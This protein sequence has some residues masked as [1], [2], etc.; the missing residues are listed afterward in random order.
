[1]KTQEWVQKYSASTVR[2]IRIVM[3]NEQYN[4][5]NN[6]IVNLKTETIYLNVSPGL[7]HEPTVLTELNSELA[8]RNGFSPD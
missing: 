7:A 1:M 3:N 2:T 5:I 6:L 4:N 8:A